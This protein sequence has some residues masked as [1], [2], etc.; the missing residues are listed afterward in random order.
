MLKIVRLIADELAPPPP[1]SS[2]DTP[3][4]F[5]DFDGTLVEIADS[6]DGIAVPGELLGSLTRL[7]ETL[8]GRL[9][10]VS[11]RSV[12]DLEGHLG[13]I[14][15]TVAGSHGGELRR[16][17][18]TSA[19]VDPLP[20]ALVDAAETFVQTTSGVRLEKKPLGLAVHYRQAPE[21]EAD[22]VA[23][24]EEVAERHE[25]RMKRGKMV[26]ELITH[27][28]HKGT[29]VAALM[30]EAPFAGSLPIFLGD[31]V[32][33]EDGFAGAAAAGGFGILVGERRETAAQYRL[34]STLAVH[35]WL[36]L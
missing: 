9:A 35:D 7:S 17:G 14:P 34:E 25:V 26:A 30:S 21:R 5:L 8:A 2:F 12:G 10:L 1:L 19:A 31:D 18:A 11:G 13:D 23:F 33:D 29:A 24:A 28:G 36:G 22:V 3:A 16:A 15:F 32:T 20:S 6:Y 27:A 4:L